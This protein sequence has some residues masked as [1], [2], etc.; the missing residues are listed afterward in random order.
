MF[1]G[2]GGFGLDIGALLGNMMGRNSSNGYGMGDGWGGMWAMWFMWIILFAII[3]ENGWGG[4]FG[5]NRGNNGGN[6]NMGY[7]VPFASSFT[8][9]AVQRGFDNQAVLSKLD[10]ITNGICSL[11]YDQLSQMNGIGQAI[12]ANGTQTREAISQLGFSMQNIANQNQIADMQRDFALQQKVS[13]CCCENR[14]LIGDLKYQMGTDTCA[15]TTALGQVERNVTD[16][17]TG[18]ANRIIDYMC[19]NELATLRNEKNIM[20]IT[21]GVVGQLNPPARPA[22][23]VQ[24]PNW[25]PVGWFNQNNTCCNGNY[26][27]GY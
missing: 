12:S 20:A 27:F 16:A 21:S 10:G 13:D 7:S 9:A 15:I 1:D 8:D 23:L 3:G 19:Q 18:A 11:G 2:N 24:N 25:P 4:L 14:T 6:G 17:V 5:G 22:Y 26:Q